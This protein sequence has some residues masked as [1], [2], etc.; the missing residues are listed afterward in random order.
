[1]CV[2]G[3]HQIVVV[4][5]ADSV[6]TKLREALVDRQAASWLASCANKKQDKPVAG[7]RQ[8]IVDS[9]MRALNERDGRIRLVW[10]HAQYLYFCAERDRPKR[11]RQQ[12]DEYAGN[13]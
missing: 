10:I 3:S 12:A 6:K 4:V 8:R 1:M 13:T 9:D 11:Q 5:Q 2:G 7:S